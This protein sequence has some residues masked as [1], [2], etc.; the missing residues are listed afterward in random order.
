MAREP[1]ERKLVDVEFQCLD[2][3]DFRFT[4]AMEYVGY[5]VK[6]PGGGTRIEWTQNQS[7]A[8]CPHNPL[9]RIDLAEG[10]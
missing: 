7:R 2:E 1:E 4:G 6:Q 5:R 9:H 8:N 3:K 10:H